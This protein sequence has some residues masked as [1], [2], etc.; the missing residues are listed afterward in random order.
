MK[1]YSFIGLSVFVAFNLLPFSRAAVAQMNQMQGMDGGKMPMP[2]SAP[3]GQRPAGQVPVMLTPDKQKRVGVKTEPVRQKIMEKVVRTVGRVDYNERAL[4]TVTTKIEGW[5]EALAVDATGMAVKKGAPLFSVY[6]PKLVQTQE[7]YLLAFKAQEKGRNLVSASRRRL[8]LWDV[9]AKQVRDLEKRGEV[10]RALPVLSPASGIVTEKMALA[11]MYVKPGM[12]LYQIADLS[13]VWVLADIYEHEL[14]WLQIGQ[15]AELSFAA[16]PGQTFRGNVSYIY[17][18]LNKGS[19][20]ATLRIELDNQDGRLKPGMYADVKIT[21]SATEAFVVPE[22]AVLDS[23][24]RQ[25][26]FVAKAGGMFEPRI[27]QIGQRLNHE[28]QVLEGLKAGEHVVTHGTFLMDSES[29]MTASMEGMMGLVGMGDWKMEGSKMGG[30]DMEGM[31]MGGMK[32]DGMKMEQTD[33]SASS[34]NQ[35]VVNGLNLHLSTEP[36]KPARGDVTLY[37]KISDASGRPVT[38]AK[39]SFTYTMAMPG[40]S[41]EMVQAKAVKDGMYMGEAFLGMNGDWPTEWTI[42]RPGQAPVK[43]KFT[44]RVGG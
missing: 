32:M 24:L 33:K 27:I 29:K 4:S 1:R 42:S 36:A 10:I 21:A 9:T 14:S 39:V 19:R 13:K 7:E 15:N 5:I 8:M 30:M 25:V 43:A 2:Q 22:S 44:V 17:P 35:L 12:P 16:W 40:M 26:V 3:G 28:V 23:G 38:D 18:Y 20:T 41:V 6:S 31:D 37:L 34:S 11:G